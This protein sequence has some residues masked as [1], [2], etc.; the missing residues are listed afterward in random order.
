MIY[1]LFFAALLFPLKGALIRWRANFTPK[2]QPVSELPSVDDVQLVSQPRS[3]LGM[4]Q[5]VKTEEGIDGMYK[6]I[7][8]TLGFLL[9]WEQMY[10]PSFMVIA[11]LHI[12]EYN[13]GTILIIAIVSSI[14]ILATVVETVLV[15][16]AVTTQEELPSF[17]LRRALDAL[18]SPTE[19]KRPYRIFV[20]PGFLAATTSWVLYIVGTSALRHFFVIK[21]MPEHFENWEDVKSCIPLLVGA[22]VFSLVL[23]ALV[24]TP[25]EVMIVRLSIQAKARQPILL[26]DTTPDEDHPVGAVR[27]RT[28]EDEYTGLINCATLIIRE[29]GWGVLYRG[30]WWTAFRGLLFV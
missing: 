27:L 24:L 15:N 2:A 4:L 11:F 20:I 5:R 12:A 28:N 29:E 13:R 16:R 21:Q 19:R 22:I 7:L 3:L 23:N 10:I 14:K 8:P 18:L 6:G 26:L 17:S 30:W 25:L 1:R 9:F